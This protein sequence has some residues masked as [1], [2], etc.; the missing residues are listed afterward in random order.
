[1][2]APVTEYIASSVPI[3]SS[4]DNNTQ[5]PAQN[6]YGD[7][8]V[9]TYITK[10]DD[11][12]FIV[13][14]Y[15][16][17]V[18]YHDNLNDPLT[19]WHVL[20]DD[21]QMGHSIASD[22]LVYL[23]DDTE[24]HRVLVFQKDGDMFRPTQM[25]ENI[26]NRPHYILYD[27]NT[28]TFYVWSS[29]NGEMY[30]MR[31]S[32]EDPHMYLTEI[33][34]LDSL[35]NTYVRSFSIIGKDIYFVSGISENPEIIRADLRTFRIKD[36]YKVP[37]SIAGMIQITKIDDYFYITVSTDNN[38]DQN[39]ATLI[40]T[41]NL[42]NLE[43]GEY[44]DVYSNFIGGGTPYCI[45]EFDGKYYLTEHRL[46]GHSIWSFSVENNQIQNVETLY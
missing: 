5:T 38:G 27:E 3:I 44:E 23:V 40:R 37:T 13:D 6:L 20:T 22:G 1:M 24:N 15:H 11:T 21:I 31:H 18:I 32:P 12:Y 25:F 10:I 8:S 17:Q 29:M 4:E 43:K 34:K 41:K 26:G 16:N 2:N 35:A 19:E 30:L 36:T 46:P 28:A 9:P 33:R 14:C 45:T 39:Y 7:L 42:K